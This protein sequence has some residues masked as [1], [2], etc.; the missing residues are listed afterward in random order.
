MT[1]R[2]RRLPGLRAGVVFASTLSLALPTRAQPTFESLVKDWSA[3]HVIEARPVRDLTLSIGHATLTVKSGNAAWVVAGGEKVGVFVR[4]EGSLEYVS[5][6][7]VEFPVLKYN[8]SKNS[9]L[10]P[11]FDGKTATLR[12]RFTEVLWLAGGAPLTSLSEGESAPLAE[13][14]AAHVKKFSRVYASPA[15]HQFAEWRLNG[16]DRSVV[17]AEL[18]GGDEDLFYVFS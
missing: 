11:V 13:A 8:T 1:T 4:G 6:D 3:L 12:D 14:F 16:P 10:K 18:S 7:P 15:T 2:A 17:R 9:G 5:A